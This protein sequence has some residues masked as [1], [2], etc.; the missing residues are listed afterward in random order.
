MRTVN[1]LLNLKCLMIVLVQIISKTESTLAGSINF[2]K[3]YNCKC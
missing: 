1:I 3:Y 2:E